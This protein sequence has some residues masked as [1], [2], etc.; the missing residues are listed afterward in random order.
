METVIMWRQPSKWVSVAVGVVFMS[1]ASDVSEVSWKPIDPATAQQAIAHP[2]GDVEYASSDDFVAYLDGSMEMLVTSLTFLHELMVSLARNADRD[3]ALNEPT[4]TEYNP[5]TGTTPPDPTQT[6][7][8]GT[9]I[10]LR[11]P[12]PGMADNLTLDTPPDPGEIQIDA[13][14]FNSLNLDELLTDTQILLQF[15]ECHLKNTIIDNDAAGWLDDTDVLKLLLDLYPL[16]L[17]TGIL[18]LELLEIHPDYFFLLVS[19]EGH[20]TYQLGMAITYSETRVSIAAADGS[21]QCVWSADG[22]EFIGCDIE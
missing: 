22:T 6:T 11:K 17:G 12:C 3:D 5:S 7:L 13:N 4:D 20:G 1:C 14:G 21:V 10:Y 2:T 18:R 16:E 8:K 9:S 15:N 19:V